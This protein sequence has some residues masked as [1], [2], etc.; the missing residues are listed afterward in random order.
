MGLLAVLEGIL[1]Q[2]RHGT[3]DADTLARDDDPR[4]AIAAN[5]CAPVGQIIADAGD[6]CS[7]ID[8]ALGLGLVQCAG[9]IQKRADDGIDIIE[10]AQVL[11]AFGRGRHHF[12]SQ[13]DLGDRSSQVMGNG[14]QELGPAADKADQPALHLV[15]GR[16]G[17]YHF[18]WTGNGKRHR[19][20]IAS[21]A[22]GRFRKTGERLCDPFHQPE[23]NQ[24]DRNRT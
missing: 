12:A 5:D 4:G 17:R 7:K 2:V 6:Q 1:D 10:R 9:I 19:E 16:C 21:Q 20:Q 15:E 11:F 24:C 22:L 23:G 13:P 8:A 14:G 3:L 18:A